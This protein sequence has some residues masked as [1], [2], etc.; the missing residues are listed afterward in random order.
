VA[1]IVKKSYP[2]GHHCAR[3]DLPLSRTT[4][5][6]V[7]VATPGVHR[8]TGGWRVVEDTVTLTEGYVTFD[9]EE[10]LP[11]RVMEDTRIMDNTHNPRRK[12]VAGTAP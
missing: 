1:S 12:V 4:L 2:I 9:L 6:P 10:L 3:A 11:Q 7:D 8:A 5:E